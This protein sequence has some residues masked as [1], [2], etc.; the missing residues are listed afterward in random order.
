VQYVL[1]V[2]ELDGLARLRKQKRGQELEAHLIQYGRL[3]FY[4]QLDVSARLER[5]Q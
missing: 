1:A 5:E 3:G 4:R 2:A